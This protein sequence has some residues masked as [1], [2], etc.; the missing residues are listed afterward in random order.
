MV[1]CFFARGIYKAD[2]VAAT[3]SSLGYSYSEE[4]L[5]RLSR[6]IYLEKQRLK[7]EEG[8]S[9]RKLSLPERIYQVDTPLG[10]I[11]REYVKEALAH[12]DQLIERA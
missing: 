1:L 12:F 8:Y 10:K 9:A 5:K 11:S 7:R 6:E 2:L 3:L 4:E